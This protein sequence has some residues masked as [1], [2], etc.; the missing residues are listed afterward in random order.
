MFPL[1]LVPVVM[2]L[3]GTTIQTEWHHSADISGVYGQIQTCKDGLGAHAKIAEEWVTFG[4]QYGL[5]FNIT[6]R[7]EFTMQ[8]QAGGSYSNTTHP[9]SRVRQVT[10]FE[11]GLALM[12]TYDQ[13]YVVNLEYTHMSN[14][15]GLSPTNAGQDVYGV[16]VGYIFGK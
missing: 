3:Y 4:V 2:L 8:P 1:C 11:A 5:T 7:V 9:E 6:E 14:G 10:K 12:L 15:Q 13:R 16:G